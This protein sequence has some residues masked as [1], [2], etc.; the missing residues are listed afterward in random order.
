MTKARVSELAVVAVRRF[1]EQRV[2][3]EIRD[4]LRYDVE[5]RGKA[6]TI[7][8]CRPPWRAGIG[9]EWTKMKIAQFRFDAESRTWS[10]YWANRNERWLEYPDAKPSADIGDLIAALDDDVSGAFFG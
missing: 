3:P 4:K 7:F 1:C 9:P 6:I 10:L 2:R 8:E 5:T